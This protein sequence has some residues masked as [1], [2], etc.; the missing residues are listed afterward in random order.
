MNPQIARARQAVAATTRL[1]IGRGMQV[2]QEGSEAYVKIDPVTCRPLRIN[3]PLLPDD[4]DQALVKAIQGYLDHEAAHIVFTDWDVVA[5]ASAAGMMSMF[6]V[7]ED[8]YIERA[9]GE[10]FP[11]SRYNLERLHD[12][13]CGDIVPKMLDERADDESRFGVLLVQ[14]ARA[15]AGQARP[16]RFMEEGG[17]WRGARIRAFVELLGPDAVARMPTLASSSECLDM[18]ELWAEASQATPDPTTIGIGSAG[19]EE[20][21]GSGRDRGSSRAQTPS[22]PIDGQPEDDGRDSSRAAQPEDPAGAGAGAG[23]VGDDAVSGRDRGSDAPETQSPETDDVPSGG[24]RGRLE[25]GERKGRARSPASAASGT[26]GSSPVAD[27]G[28][29]ECT[30][31]VRAPSPSSTAATHGATQRRVRDVRGRLVGADSDA[32]PATAMDLP[33]LPEDP[34]EDAVSRSITQSATRAVA[35]ADYRVFSRDRDR[36]E[37][38]EIPEGYRDSW[39]AELDRVTAGMVGAMQRDV[40]RMMA[41]RSRSAHL[42]GLRSGRL[43]SASL[44]RLAVGDDRTFR[45]KVTTEAKSTAVTLLV[46]NSASMSG[47][48]MLVAMASTYALATTLERVAIPCEVIG[49]TTDER[50]PLWDDEDTPEPTHQEFSRYAGIMMP[51]YK[52]F[53]QRLTPSNRQRFAVAAMTQSSVASNVDGESLQYAAMRLL[54]RPEDRKI[55]IVLSDGLPAVYRGNV[56]ELEAHLAETV[57]TLVRTGIEV[58]G[59]GIM[60]D[61]VKRFYPR[62]LVIE[63]LEELPRAVMGELRAILET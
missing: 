32:D 60:T 9:M 18:A 49:Y 53:A 58:V 36:I 6:N 48:R 62:H 42:V 33:D 16:Q 63:A 13:V 15:M 37:A 21:D 23:S 5:E 1:L 54:P 46:D 55:M 52:P 29:N 41:A 25:A 8:T 44:H 51:V 24:G 45:R 30:G 7:I 14:A 28:E 40:E 50:P 12:L 61:A 39:L 10:R 38:A 27:E 19:G 56:D 2:T 3:I 22:T 35:S 26:A 17:H 47:E 59:I 31:G 20:G 34:F 4:A 11:G 43:H 57:R